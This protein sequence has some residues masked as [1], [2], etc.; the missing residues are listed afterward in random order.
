[1]GAES[2]SSPCSSPGQWLAAGPPGPGAPQRLITS[3]EET[4]QKTSPEPL[5]QHPRENQTPQHGVSVRTS[6]RLPRVIGCSA[7]VVS[8]Q[9]AQRAVLSGRTVETARGALERCITHRVWPGSPPKRPPVSRRSRI[10][11]LETLE[12]FASSPPGLVRTCAH[13]PH[14]LFSS[15]V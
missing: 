1:M 13:L 11:S 7:R 4:M 9:R 8:G 2:A 12:L 3:W 14:Y 15:H 5:V 10:S 6:H